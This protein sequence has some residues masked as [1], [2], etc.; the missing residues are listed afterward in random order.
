MDFEVLVQ[1]IESD[2]DEEQICNV[3][4]VQPQQLLQNENDCTYN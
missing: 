4:P 2:E 3:L 1:V